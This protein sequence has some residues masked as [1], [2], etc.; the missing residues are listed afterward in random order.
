M[1]AMFETASISVVRYVWKV[2]VPV[3]SPVSDGMLVDCPAFFVI[4]VFWSV[5]FFPDGI[6]ILSGDPLC[7]GVVSV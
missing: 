3:E 6:F 5:W 1:L 2:D 4:R 7:D